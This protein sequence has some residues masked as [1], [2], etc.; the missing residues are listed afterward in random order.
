MSGRHG[1]IARSTPGE[2][3]LKMGK[4]PDVPTRPL[5]YVRRVIGGQTLSPSVT[6]QGG[7]K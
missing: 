7:M 4:A 5:S 3:R 6:N 1:E 2:G